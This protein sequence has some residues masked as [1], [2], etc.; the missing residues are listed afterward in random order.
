MSAV[1]W[2]RVYRMRHG[3]ETGY[4]HSWRDRRFT[5]GVPSLPGCISEGDTV[6]EALANIREAIALHVED[7]M[8]NGEAIPANVPAPIRVKVA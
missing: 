3:N 6:E 8:A 5:V 4:S 1:K 2:D 7:M